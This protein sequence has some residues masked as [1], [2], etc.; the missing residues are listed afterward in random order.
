MTSE[1]STVFMGSENFSLPILRALDRA[2]DEGRIQLRAVVTQ[3]DRPAGRGR[4]LTSTP[5]KS[6]AQ[7]RGIPVLQPPKVRDAESVRD[8][9]SLEPDLLVVASFGQIIPK[10]L[11]DP[12]THGCLN[13]HPSLLPR[14]RGASPISSPILAGDTETGTSLMVMVPKMDAGP[15]LA[16]ERTVIGAHETAGELEQRLA[17]MSADL[18]MKHLDAW[19]R[20]EIRGQPQVEEAATYTSRLEKSDG[21]VDWSEPATA[22]ERRVR[23]FDPWPGTFTVWDGQPVK[24]L[25]AHVAP[26][27]LRPG[28]TSVDSEGQLL[29]GT[30]HDL[31]V[32]ET[33]QLAG[34]RPLPSAAVLQ[35]HAGLA[36]A[37]LGDASQWS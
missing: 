26:G 14:Y 31:L 10:A 36:G 13:L 29:V 33:M 15:V 20:G 5:V 30:G 25:R 18:L 8:I 28:E 23:A 22:I 7:E 21:R 19:C 1:I 17:V 24:L 9:L 37:L 16:Q 35:G 6:Y 11:L 2:S 32:V 4:R 12:P 27:A 3:P 34:G